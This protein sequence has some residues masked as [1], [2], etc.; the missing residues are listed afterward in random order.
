MTLEKIKQKIKQLELAWH[1]ESNN[2]NL[3]YLNGQLTAWN[4]ILREQT[5]KEEQD[6]KAMDE[7]SKP[8]LK[9]TAVDY[10]AERYNYITWMRNRDEISAGTA[11]EWRTKFL[12]VAKQ[13]EKEQMQDLFNE[14]RKSGI[15]DYI[16]NQEGYDGNGISFEEYYR[17]TYGNEDKSSE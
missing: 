9:Q 11:D 4:E 10:L 6:Y 7:E 3:T 8:Q 1:K 17:K 13:M 16:D 14:G 5:M 15:E 2:D 12:R